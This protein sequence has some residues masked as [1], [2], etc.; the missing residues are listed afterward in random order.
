MQCR[1]RSTRVVLQGPPVWPQLSSSS[2]PDHADLAWRFLLPISSISRG[3]F[4][5]ISLILCGVSSSRS[6][7]SRVA[8]PPAAPAEAR[9]YALPGCHQAKVAHPSP[10]LFEVVAM[11]AAVRLGEFK[12]QVP[13][14]MNIK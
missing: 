5:Q 11:E 7:R 4:F 14:P 13:A 3:I 1:A 8:Y 12:P 9:V 10:H 2:P 6:R